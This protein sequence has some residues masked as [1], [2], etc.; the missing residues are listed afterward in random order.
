MLRT[1]IIDD[2]LHIQETLD[3]MLKTYCPNVKVIAKANS[4]KNGV[5]AIKQYHPDLILLDIKMDDGT[6]FDLLAKLEP[7]NF[8][9]VFITAYDKYAIKAFKFNAL[10]FL[11]KPVDPDELTAAVN[12]AEKVIQKEF[13]TQLSNMEDNLRTDDKSQKK[14]ILKT[15]DNI[16]LVKV[17]DIIYCESDGG[18]TAIYRQNEKRILVS[19]TLKDYD[20]MLSD[21]GF[22]RVHKSYLINI[23]YIERFEK[24]EGGYVILTDEN[25]IPVASRKRDE[26]LE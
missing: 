6:G 17:R 12:K 13:N 1:I 2:E 8:K 5:E 26:L 24:A 18:Y 19:N 9:V 23:N 3:N 14:I 7:I 22:Y 4:V 21:F 20:E 11:L 10:D 25:K 16:Y 15:F